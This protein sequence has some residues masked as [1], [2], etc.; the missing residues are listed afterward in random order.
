MDD[1]KRDE[2]LSVA[3][4]LMCPCD[5]AMLEEQLITVVIGQELTD[6]NGCLIEVLTR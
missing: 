5:V 3:L 4:L 1:V 2:Q 6:G